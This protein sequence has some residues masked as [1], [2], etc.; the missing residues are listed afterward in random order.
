[1]SRRRSGN[2]RARLFTVAVVASAYAVGYIST[3]RTRE[4]FVPDSRY[5]GGMS[6]WYG[7]SSQESAA[8]EVAKYSAQFGWASPPADQMFGWGLVQPRVVYPALSTPFVKLFGIDG[9]AVVS[10][11]AMALLVVVLTVMLGAR[12]GNVAAVGT[13][14]L[15]CTSSQ[16]MFYGSA[17]LTESLCALWGALLLAV[18]WR[19]AR[20]PARANIVLLVALTVVA[21]FTRQATLIP[22]GAFVTAWLGAAV[23]R[24]KPNRWRAPALAVGATAVTV[25]LL[26]TWLF[27]S[28]SQAKQF[29]D[30]TGADTLVE[31]ILKAPQLAWDIVRTDVINVNAVDRPL[32]VFFALALLSMVLFWR[33]SESHLLL[34]AILAYELYNVT[35]GVPTAFRY[36]MPGLVFFATSVAMLFAEVGAR[37]RGHDDATD[38][39]LRDVDSADRADARL[40]QEPAPVRSA[41]SP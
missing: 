23:L 27:P 35:N 30:K 5:Y 16:L 34:G 10:G 39:V 18:A 8:D 31:A 3:I 38:P 1:M 41:P 2:L 22:A 4:L 28:F 25:Q 19:H 37:S 14:V 13:M 12:F 26:Q 9:L 15:I 20:E 36:S 32:L 21:G 33:R 40:E 7:G 24:Q 29:K 17:M 6:L 11:L